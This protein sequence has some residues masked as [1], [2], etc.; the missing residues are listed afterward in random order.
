[1]DRSYF[2]NVW[3]TKYPQQVKETIEHANAVRYSISNEAVKQNAI[4]ISNEWEEQLK[5]MPFVSKQ[6]GRM[7]AL[8]K[9]KSKIKIQRKP[10]VQYEVGPSLKRMREAPKQISSQTASSINLGQ[11][12]IQTQA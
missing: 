3:N 9:A 4:T 7:S 10:R 11:S 1:M 8:L 6:K 2:Y 5:A 12:Q